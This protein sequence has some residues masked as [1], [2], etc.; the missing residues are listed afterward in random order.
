MSTGKQVI[1]YVGFALGLIVFVVAVWLLVLFASPGSSIFGTTAVNA[2]QVYT[3][4]SA[5][6]IPGI[7]NVLAHRNIIIE[8]RYIPIEVRVRKAGQQDAGSIQVWE[9]STGI[10]FNNVRRTH[11]EW[12]QVLVE[13]TDDEGRVFGEVFYRIR[14]VEP[15]GIVNRDGF[16][17]INLFATEDNTAYQQPF[18][19]ILDTG[20][21]HVNFASD[22][23]LV[24][25]QNPLLVDTLQVRNAT[26]T[27]TLPAPPTNPEH[28][29]FFVDIG[30]VVVDTR[31]VILRCLSPVRYNVTINCNAGDFTFGDVGG[32]FD[33]DGNVNTVSVN[34]IGGDLTV[35]GWRVNFAQRVGEIGG[36][37]DFRAPNGA[38]SIVRCRGLFM[39]TTNANLSVS[40]RVTSLD[41]ESTGIGSVNVAQVGD[42]DSWL[43]DDRVRVITLNGSVSVFR[44]WV[45]S[46]VES[47]FG[48]IRI[49]FADDVPLGTSIEPTL[50]I[51][52]F[53]GT[54][55]ARN[56]VGGVDIFV[57]ANGNAN[58]FADFRQIR[59]GS[60]VYEGSTNPHRNRGNMT[61]TF[62]R[63]IPYSIIFIHRAASAQNNTNPQKLTTLSDHVQVP[64]GATLVND[65]EYHVRYADGGTVSTG[66]LRLSTSNTLV[67]N[68]R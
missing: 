32:N 65:A 59:T 41:Y 42:E 58:I 14:I 54:V 46:W 49:D 10:S 34:N 62:A 16:V 15:S 60:V 64:V 24:V 1:M 20:R 29:S 40:G 68:S 25:H 35:R 28:Y 56:I 4:Y 43:G 13:R 38:L 6:E 31:T 7:A 53:D 63:D 52:A 36:D 12:E 26:G 61:I 57:R 45:N 47:T 30:N 18:N 21:S 50:T 3:T 66:N 48:A 22:N 67:I 39:R 9:N 19:F 27:I 37:V 51:R 17:F 8:S 2:R 44:V 23:D 11:V 33:I 55:T 5:E